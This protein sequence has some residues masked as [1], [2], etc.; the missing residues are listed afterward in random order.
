M[1]KSRGAALLRLADSA[2]LVA[3]GISA[4][5][6]GF[7]S[8]DDLLAFLA[9]AMVWQLASPRLPRCVRSAV[10]S[11]AL[12][13]L[14]S[15]A[16]AGVAVRARPELAY[17]ALAIVRAGVTAVAATVA[18]GIASAGISAWSGRGVRRPVSHGALALPGA[19]LCSVLLWSG[20]SRP[21][22]D[23]LVSVDTG[24]AVAVTDSRFLSFTI[25]TS[26]LLGGHWWGD[27][28]N[29]RQPTVGGGR[30]EPLSLTGADLLRLTRAL[31]PAF[32]RIGGTEADRVSFGTSSRAGAD[33][34]TLTAERWA[35]VRSFAREAG[36]DLVFTLNA[37]PSMRSATGSWLADD[38]RTL[39][40]AERDGAGSVAVWELGNE[41][42]A[43]AITLGRGVTPRQYAADLRHLR[44]VLGT[45]G[46]AASVSAFSSVFMPA[47]GEMP[48]F[49]AAWPGGVRPS[50]DIIAWHYYPQQSWR[51]LLRYRPASPLLLDPSTFADADRHAAWMRRWRDAHAAGAALWLSE[52]GP[53]QCGGEP[54]LSDG[55]GSALWWL[56][57]LGRMAKAGQTVV[58][59]QSLVGGAYGL[60]DERTFAPRP[61]YAASVLWKRL[62]GIGVLAVRRE[63]GN[64]SLH[65]FAHCANDVP[66]GVSVLAVN[67]SAGPVSLTV[68]GVSGRGELWRFAATGSLTGR[69]ALINGVPAGRVT[70]A[71]EPA[72][73]PLKQPM[74]LQ[75]FSAA[76][77][78]FPDARAPA[79]L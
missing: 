66:G 42:N 34:L 51:C 55:Y 61:G 9:A 29:W 30:A 16:L 70:D 28:V 58:V 47:I 46:G 43:H 4:L 31:S 6:V 67:G 32:L 75:P 78:R 40:E 37:G 65:V 33:G 22:G 64:D 76:F 72:P 14:A 48:S 62:M 13:S 36:V 71:G 39:L 56:A 57:H 25:D 10:T 77:A 73:L 17:V 79:C 60:L 59:R 38:F 50:A 1:R 49:L 2:A 35:A 18:A 45:S 20:A 8:R 27:A 52:T 63:G 15:W 74:T 24:K 23:V 53:A 19:A 44:E 26:F 68:D 54:G 11:L 12:G 69:N 5:A 21:P 41:V 3:C 7:W